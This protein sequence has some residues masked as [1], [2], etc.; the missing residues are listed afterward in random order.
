MCS[1]GGIM[2]VLPGKSGDPGRTGSDNRQFVN[3]VLYLAPVV[4]LGAVLALTFT[5]G[6]RVVGR[7]ISWQTT[8]PFGP[9]PSAG[10]FICWC[11]RLAGWTL[12][13]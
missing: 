10:F 7:S 6:L 3:G 2:S 1:G 5:L 13:S 4:F 11:A 8:L 12:A 9:F